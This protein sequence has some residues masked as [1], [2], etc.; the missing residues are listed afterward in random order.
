MTRKVMRIRS[1]LLAW[2]ALVVLTS[3]GL[4]QINW[5]YDFQLWRHSRTAVGEIVEL[6][7]DN[8]STVRYRFKVGAR[9][10][11]GA[12]QGYNAIG[13]AAPG[14]SLVVYYLPSDPGISIVDPPA[15][16]LANESTAI[17]LAAAVFPALAIFGRRKI[18]PS[19]QR[20]RGRDNRGRH[21][22]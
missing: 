16:E 10:V 21:P 1:R 7:P 18:A 14:Q 13:T 4:A 2:F 9:S 8:H 19:S 20:S 5:W 6:L 22:H 12:Q 3:V 15:G 17:L 11:T